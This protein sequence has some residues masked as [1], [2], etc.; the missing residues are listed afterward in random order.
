[1][2]M[3]GAMEFKDAQKSDVVDA[4]AVQKELTRNLDTKVKP[5]G[6]I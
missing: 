1:M 6:A 4:L 3:A 5:P 2:R